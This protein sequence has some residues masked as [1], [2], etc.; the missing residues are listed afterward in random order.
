MVPETTKETT[1]KETTAKETTAKRQRG[2]PKKYLTEEEA[3]QVYREQ[4]KKHQNKYTQHHRDWSSKISSNQRS[5]VRLI[6]K[7]ILKDDVAEQIYNILLAQN[8]SV[9]ETHEREAQLNE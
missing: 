3:K 2:R 1:A 6:E 4:Q 7:L 5:A 8:E 9:G